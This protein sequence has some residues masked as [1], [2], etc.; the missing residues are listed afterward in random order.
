VH[1]AVNLLVAL[2]AAFPGISQTSG[3]ESS[4]SFDD[5]E[6]L[7]AV[8]AHP[9]ML[10][11][12]EKWSRVSE[13]RSPVFLVVRNSVPICAEPRDESRP[14]VPREHLTRFVRDEGLQQ[15]LGSRF[16]ATVCQRLARSFEQRNS[17]GNS[18]PALPHPRIEFI[19]YE[20]LLR[21][22]ESGVNRGRAR[23]YAQFSL[24]GYTEDGKA[25]VYAAYTCGGLCGE[26]WLFLLA[27][28]EGVWRVV[29]WTSVWMS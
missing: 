13:I 11:E 20:A 23:G 8:F 24:P 17:T 26:G 18:L 3:R 10:G 16:S 19:E 6:A 14:C 9:R 7:A 28:T 12:M 15:R 21:S 2:A 4:M 25:L 29:H 1:V 22:F 5:A 27:R